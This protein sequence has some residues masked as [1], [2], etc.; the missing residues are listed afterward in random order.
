MADFAPDAPVKRPP[1]DRRLAWRGLL[2]QLIFFI[3]LPLSL[4]SLVVSFGSL[5][6]HQ[7]AMRDLVGERDER[8]SRSVARAISDQLGHR[9]SLIQGVVLGASTRAPADFL[10]T[11][12]YFLADFD[13]GIALYDMDG[14]LLAA[15]I[16]DWPDRVPKSLTVLPA[17][18]AEPVFSP[19]VLSSVGDV[20]MSVAISDGRKLTAVGV[21]SVT[22]LVRSTLANSFI[23]GDQAAA[24]VV[25]ANMQSLFQTDSRP[26]SEHGG[27]HPGI[28][29]AL[30]GESGVTHFPAADGDEH[31]VAYSPILPVGWAFALDEKW[32]DV[33]NPV[34][35]TTQFA[36]L[37]I[38][39]PFLVV[40]VVLWFGLRQIVQPLQALAARAAELGWGRFQAIEKPVG[41]IVEI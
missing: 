2:P 11:A 25:D 17:G 39:P 7:Q 29:L 5:N 33:D 16:E 40:L 27:I 20:L 12:S 18:N 26:L 36:P 8:T 15:S 4:I 6:L 22:A 28:A 19:P 35:R 24:F 14:G 38:I 34:L 30:Q 23:P 41:G 31:V 9:G 21:F 10:T 1:H 37:A 3:I 32:E 13:I